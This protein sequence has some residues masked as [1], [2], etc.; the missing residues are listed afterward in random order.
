M[1]IKPIQDAMLSLIEAVPKEQLT[2]C[3]LAYDAIDEGDWQSAVRFLLKAAAGSEADWADTARSI[4]SALQPSNDE[5]R[6]LSEL[7]RATEMYR[8]HGHGHHLWAAFLALRDADRS[9]DR[10]D[11]QAV[12]DKNRETVLIGI[13]EIARGML[14]LGEVTSDGGRKQ[15]LNTL[16]WAEKGV[17]SAEASKKRRNV[18]ERLR[19]VFSTILNNSDA[20]LA[21][22]DR[23][24]E[25]ADL[26]PVWKDLK[27][28]DG[29]FQMV[30]D[31]T[32]ESKSN[33]RKIWEEATSSGIGNLY[34]LDA[35][36]AIDKRKAE[37]LERSRK[38]RARASS[39]KPVK[40]MHWRNKN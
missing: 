11:L 27:S 38:P 16:K 5:I 10:R 23:A 13:E 22:F 31:E 29:A 28:F 34:A 1:S 21:E 17:A 3:K 40:P 32:G 9:V 12:I 25:T 19:V 24:R 14:G 33:V 35:D 18:V 6:M 39:H 8:C 7:E 37:I 15:L 4:A 20:K 36:S 30:A 2:R 26:K